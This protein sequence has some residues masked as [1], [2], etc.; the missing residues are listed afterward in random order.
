M[1]KD[2]TTGFNVCKKCQLEEHNSLYTLIPNRC[3]QCVGESAPNKCKFCK[4]GFLGSN[5]G[6]PD[7]CE[8]KCGPN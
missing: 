7:L 5:I 8:L 1:T 6:N 4:T 3:I 2:A